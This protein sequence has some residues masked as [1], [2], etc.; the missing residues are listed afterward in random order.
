MPKAFRFLLSLALSAGA[1][2]SCFRA[3]TLRAPEGIS[4]RLVFCG[5]PDNDLLAALG[6]G[7]GAPV[8]RF[9]TPAAALEAAPPGGSVLI[10][11]DDYPARTTALSARLFALAAR[12]GLRLYVEYPSFLPGLESGAPRGAAW[13]RA[14]VSS[15]AFGP[16]LARLRILGLH[17][18]RFVPVPA[19]ASHIVLARVAGLDQ[20]VYGLPRETYPVLFELPGV[21]SGA[22]LVATTKLSQFATA[23]Y[24]PA[25]AWDSIWAMILR[26]LDPGGPSPRLA[27]TASVLP[28]FSRDEALP[29][30]AERRALRRGM[31]WFFNAGLVL[32][33][34][35]VK[36]YEGEAA[37]WP[38]RVGPAP[39]RDLPPGDGRFGLLE[40]FNSLILPDGS[41]NARW[42]RRHDCNGE[43]A[44]AMG[45]AGT[46]L[47][48]ERLRKTGA[49]IADFLYGTS[50][51]SRGERLDPRHPAFGLFGWNDVARYY[52]D[53]DGY[54][55]YYG[56]DNARGLLGMMS[57]ASALGLDRWN[58][59]LALGLLA[60]LRLSGRSGFQP[61][62]IDEAP[63][64]AAGWRRYFRSGETSLS[65]HFQ[66]YLWACYL[67]AYAWSRE[68]LFLER[69]KAAVRLIMEA[70]PERW[71]W[72]NGIQQER[73][74]M[75]LPL[76]WL[77]RVED[78]PAHR[79]WLRRMAEDIGRGQDACGAVRE[80][81][82]PGT[83]GFA[84]A[85]SNEA[86][87]TSESSLI[88]KNGDPVSD[89]LYTANFAFLGLHEAAAATGEPLYRDMEDKLA[90]FLCR[91]QARSEVRPELDGAW[92]RA[93]EFRRWEY[94]AS[95]ADAG[96]GAWSIESG[97]T[98]TWITM[99]LALRRRGT[100]LWELTEGLAMAEPLRLNRARLIPDDASRVQISGGR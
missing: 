53:M 65:P 54:G 55:V 1:V 52:G 33:A 90:A 32:N 25:A 45:L 66:S 20:A 92:F 68:P 34:D 75:L 10:L 26:W 70:Y 17:G 89:L 81:L 39:R 87:G 93:F 28:S 64:E 62:R 42:W 5:R 83:S 84:P 85:A 18:C 58:E 30:D 27:W 73:A 74:R 97:W 24:A 15:D 86:Y 12:K 95:N 80:E 78:T 49:R 38:D 37:G 79:A 3:E 72:A 100:S 8:A 63:L 9:A 50:I 94:W 48:D 76:A 98:Q 61:D 2:S 82:G 6:K 36:T 44:G 51:M 19:S 43:G 29:A 16:D 4:R 11:A 69:A 21:S 56:D 96:W 67:R 14:V 59:R 35:A 13:E 99:V 60:N 7:A 91:I 88:Q 40:G 41:Q 23:R 71:Q 46:A 57:A 47:G 77:L 22:V 31:D